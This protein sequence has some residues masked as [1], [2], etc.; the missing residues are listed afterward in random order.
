[1]VGGV[2]VVRLIYR[3]CSVSAESVNTHA[4]EI[5]CGQGKENAEQV[6]QQGDFKA[7]EQIHEVDRVVS[8]HIHAEEG[9]VEKVVQEQTVTDDRI[10]KYQRSSVGFCV[11]LYLSRQN[12][13]ESV[14][15]H[16][17]VTGRLGYV[18]KFGRLM[19]VNNIFHLGTDVKRHEHA[20][21]E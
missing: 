17:A 4:H 6:G 15:T 7:S 21:R 19:M 13:I 12:E 20:K 5:A 16:D 2:Y 14:Q 3:Q 8:V 18:Y 10:S 11:W 9:A 1:M